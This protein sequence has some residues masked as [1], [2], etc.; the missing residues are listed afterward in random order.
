MNMTFFPLK[1]ELLYMQ[2]REYEKVVLV[3]V[4]EWESVTATATA[5]KDH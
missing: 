2:K 5:N 1:Y 3:G 4:A